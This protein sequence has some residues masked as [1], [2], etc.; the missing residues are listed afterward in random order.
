MVWIRVRMCSH[1]KLAKHGSIQPTT[2]CR[3][4]FCRTISNTRRNLHSSLALS[5]FALASR[6]ARIL[7]EWGVFRRVSWFRPF[8]R[9][10]PW[11]DCSWVHATHRQDREHRFFWCH[12]H[13]RFGKRIQLLRGAHTN[14]SVRK[15]VEQVRKFK[16]KGRK[17]RKKLRLSSF[18]HTFMRIF[19]L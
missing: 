7:R 19:T 10:M 11:L 16:E 12:R 18:A 6:L 14:Y 3:P 5:P 4:H 13:R 2:W 15:M 8:C 1:L 9:S 17:R